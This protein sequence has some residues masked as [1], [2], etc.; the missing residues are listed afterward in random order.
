MTRSL[1]TREKILFLILALA[2]IGV[3]Y[4][5]FVFVPANDSVAAAENEILDA[6]TELV[7]LNAIKDIMLSMEA[8]IAE[9]KAAGANV[10]ELPEF[11]N[12]NY[13]YNELGTI[14][15]PADDKRTVYSDVTYDG[16][17]VSRAVDISFKVSS[18]DVAKSIVGKLYNCE[19]PCTITSLS[20]ASGESEDLSKGSV[21]VKLSV[22]FFEF[23]ES[24]IVEAP[25]ADAAE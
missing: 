25:S 9:F 14:L 5:Y 4:Y 21:T 22:T 11:P 3:G 12:H 20:F 23:D 16:N 1:N 15:M 2:L 24:V 17:L 8:D 19:Y 6:E 18:Y 13:V 10:K 7:T